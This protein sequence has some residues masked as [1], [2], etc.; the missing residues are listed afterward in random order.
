MYYT[1]CNTN[2][3]YMLTYRVIQHKLDESKGWFQIEICMLK[4]IWRWFWN[5]E[6]MTF[7]ALQPVFMKCIHCTLYWTRCQWPLV[8][9]INPWFLSKFCL[10][11][12]LILS[13][14]DSISAKN[15]NWLHEIYILFGFVVI[16][17]IF[18][19]YMKSELLRF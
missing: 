2:L 19:T 12:H 11:F 13:L 7:L 18:T 9:K 15:E 3:L 5:P 4:T 1:I 8:S 17:Q 10:F 14:Y 6:I 16:L